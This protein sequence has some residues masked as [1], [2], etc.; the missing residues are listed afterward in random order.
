MCYKT[1]TVLLEKV[2]HIGVEPKCNS[3]IAVSY[4]QCVVPLF[5]VLNNED[6][7]TVSDKAK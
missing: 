4:M 2:P 3:G 1:I 5:V 6:F 7:N